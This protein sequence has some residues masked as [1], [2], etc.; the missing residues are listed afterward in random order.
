MSIN[1]SASSKGI[2]RRRMLVISLMI[3]LGIAV[4]A[5][6]VWIRTGHAIAPPGLMLVADLWKLFICRCISIDGSIQLT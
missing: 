1:T 6:F 5:G 3:I 4:T 2:P